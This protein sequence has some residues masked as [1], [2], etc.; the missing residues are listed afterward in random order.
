MRYVQE[1]GAGKPG[2]GSY[3]LSGQRVS[4]DRIPAAIAQA[5]TDSDA[6]RTRIGTVQ[7]PTVVQPPSD[8]YDLRKHSGSARGFPAASDGSVSPP[9]STR[10]PPSSGRFAAASTTPPK[11]ARPRAESQPSPRS[12]TEQRRRFPST[13]KLEYVDPHRQKSSTRMGAVRPPGDSSAPHRGASSGQV[14][15]VSPLST[16]AVGDA[17]QRSQEQLRDALKHIAHKRYDLAIR[18]LE[19]VLYTAPDN[20][21]AG[22]WL[23]VCRA[24][25]LMAEGER[26]AAV[27]MYQRLLERDPDNYE[28]AKEISAYEKDRA[29]RA[30]PFGRYFTKNPGP[31]DDP[32]GPRTRKK[33]ER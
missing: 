12:A 15:V 1:R 21:E 5:A 9:A 13:T 3:A 7:T 32:S 27:R 6:A 18:E 8:T 24:R 28:A 11:S 26:G 4:S 19:D 29:L 16:V 25:K 33:S 2:A 22:R 10:K 20:E 17:P 30:V 23:L 14:P 31:R